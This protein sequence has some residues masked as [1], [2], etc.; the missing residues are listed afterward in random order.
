MHTHK[1]TVGSLFAGV[2]GICLGFKTAEY[3][4]LGY[5]LIW[6]NEIDEYAG[7]TY[8][9]NFDHNLIAGDIEKIVDLNIIQSEQNRY[10]NIMNEVA[11][12]EER[13]K[14]KVLIEKCEEEKQIYREKQKQILSSK[15]DVL[16]GGF[17]CQAFSIAGEQKGFDDHR[18]NLFISII[19]LIRLLDSVHGKPRVLFLE[20]VK[21]LMSHDGGRT[22]KVIKSKLEKEGYIIKEKVLNTMDFSHLPQNR[23]RIYIVGFLNKKDAEKFTMFDNIGEFYIN[24][25]VDERVRDIKKVIDYTLT[26]NTGDKYYYTKEKYPK[27]FITEEEYDKIPE[28]YRKDVRINLDESITEEYQFYQLRR[29]MYVRKNMS[30]VCPTLTANMG[31]GGHNVPLIKVKDGI[32]KL[33]PKETFKLQGFPVGNG[34]ELPTKYINRPYP[35][36]RLYKQAGNAV[37]VPIIRLIAEQILR[38]LE[39]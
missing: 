22:Y 33:T 12:D 21:N 3:R 16:N 20:N 37:S 11:T 25:T 7:E 29:G 15:I 30:N 17:P 18:G 26:K 38:V 32:R 5:N 27:Y 35:E 14:Y 1:F 4:G 6:A 8:R 28:S 23:E 19:K 24:K 31:T 9:H 13:I 39:E 10:I 2:G 36:S 34:Y